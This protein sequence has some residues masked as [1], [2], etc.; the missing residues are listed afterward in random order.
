MFFENLK[1]KYFGWCLFA[2]GI[3]FFKIIENVREFD[4]PGLLTNAV[5]VLVLA[6]I[7]YCIAYC[8]R[9]LLSLLGIN[10]PKFLSLLLIA[11][12]LLSAMYVSYTKAA[13]QNK[14]AAMQVGEKVFK[15]VAGVIIADKADDVWDAIEENVDAIEDKAEEIVYGTL[16]HI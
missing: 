15:F 14:E 1:R 8:V 13:N 16:D 7:C 12:V 5:T 2:C 3:G 11:L 9:A 10:L 4:L 6:F